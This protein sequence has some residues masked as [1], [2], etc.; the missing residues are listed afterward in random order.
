MTALKSSNLASAAYNAENETL[1]I[2]FKSGATYTYSD[3]PE[4]VYENLLSAASPG[5]YFASDIRDAF[6]FTKG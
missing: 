6:S 1:A 3:V 2:T 4:T 5:S